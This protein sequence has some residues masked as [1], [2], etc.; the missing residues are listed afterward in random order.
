MTKQEV[1][2]R[3]LIPAA[4]LEEYESWNLCDCIGQVIKAWQYDDRDI[5]RL[6]LIMT[7]HDI[8]FSKEE[9]SRYMRLYLSEKDTDSQRLSMLEKRRA[10]SL[11]EIH[12]KEMQLDRLD[13]LRYEI[14]KNKGQQR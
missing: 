2:E 10:A 13:Y 12:W 3:Y 8:G 7:L 4:V 6:S 5:E 9:I 14:Q 1:A 11:A